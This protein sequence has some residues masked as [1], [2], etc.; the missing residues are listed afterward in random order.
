[1]EQEPLM[2]DNLLDHLISITTQLIN[3]SNEALA[4]TIHSRDCLTTLNKI[5]I[6]LDRSIRISQRKLKIKLDSFQ[7][8]QSKLESQLQSLLLPPLTPLQHQHLHY[9]HF[10]EPHPKSKLNTHP[11]QLLEPILPIHHH[12]S[13]TSQL[14]SPSLPSVCSDSRSILLD[15]HARQ[16]SKLLPP[17]PSDSSSSSSSRHTLSSASSSSSLATLLSPFRMAKQ[18]LSFASTATTSSSD[19]Q[20]IINTDPDLSLSIRR[21][22][23][24][25]HIPSNII[26]TNHHNTTTITSSSAPVF[27]DTHFSDLHHRKLRLLHSDHYPP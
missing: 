1:M 16:S 8:Y 12:L 20:P 14:L 23:I 9:H 22:S 17:P 7:T 10:I 2:V 4:T 3:S 19:N 25:H 21:E 18:V 6:A 24:H 27:S 5:D 15:H 26:H 13:P 11:D